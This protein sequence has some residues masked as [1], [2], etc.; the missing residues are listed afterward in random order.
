MAG[1]LF[2]VCSVRRPGAAPQGG[3]VGRHRFSTARSVTARTRVP[4]RL[5]SDSE[6]KACR[7]AKGQG[8]WLR[9]FN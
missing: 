9:A 5:D 1:G 7:R 4:T 8:A 2:N 6:R 3:A